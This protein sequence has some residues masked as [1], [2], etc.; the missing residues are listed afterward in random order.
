MAW[1][2]R[3]VVGATGGPCRMVVSG[4]HADRR[5]DVRILPIAELVTTSGWKGTPA[6]PGR[7]YRAA[8]NPAQ[9]PSD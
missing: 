5:F 1:T 9:E 7:A 4:W 3:H 8:G 6:R 2:C